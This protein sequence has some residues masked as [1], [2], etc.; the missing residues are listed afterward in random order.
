VLENSVVLEMV[1]GIGIRIVMFNE[2][3]YCVSF[4][5]MG[6]TKFYY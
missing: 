6:S 2:L 1:P 4:H 5:V 3:S